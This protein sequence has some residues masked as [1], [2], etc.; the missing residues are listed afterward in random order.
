MFA[1]SHIKYLKVYI[2]SGRNSQ[3]LCDPNL[4]GPRRIGTLSGYSYIP[5]TFES[6][7]TIFVLFKRQHM[8]MIK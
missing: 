8:H 1:V 2:T 7:I 6:L 3:F 5:H 4:L